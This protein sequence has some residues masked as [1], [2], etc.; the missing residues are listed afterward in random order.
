MYLNCD[1]GVKVNDHKTLMAAGA[2]GIDI[3]ESIAGE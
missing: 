1:W 2:R 3:M